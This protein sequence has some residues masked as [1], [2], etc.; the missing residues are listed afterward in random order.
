MWGIRPSHLS[1]MLFAHPA[2]N[3]LLA[4]AIRYANDGTRASSPP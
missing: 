3:F 2:L 1:K 4:C